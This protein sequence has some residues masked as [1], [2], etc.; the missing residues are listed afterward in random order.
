M[1]RVRL[2]EHNI[3][4][5]IVII[6]GGGAGLSAAAAAAEKGADVIV[7][8]KRNCTGGNTAMASNIFA[9][10][11]PVQKRAMVDASRDELFKAMIDW[12]HWR[13]D[14]RIIRAYV[15]KSGDTIR[16]LEDKGCSFELMPFFPN[17]TPLVVHKPAR[18]AM[19]TDML[20]KSC[21]ER[22]VKIFVRTEVQKILTGAGGEITGVLALRGNRTFNIDATRVI[23]CTGGYGGNKELINRYAP[24]YYDNM[25]CL[26]LP[27]TGDGL[28]LGIEAGA[29]TEGLGMLQIEGPCAP[30][31]IRLMID[32]PDSGQVSI[33]LTQIAIEPYA[34]WLNKN[35][36]RFIDETIGHSPF[37]AA[38]GVLR[39]PDGMCYAILDQSM[40]HMMAEEGIVIVRGPLAKLIGTSLPGLERELRIQSQAA[41]LS[42]SRV[43]TDLCNGCGVCVNSCPLN[44]ISLDTIVADR[45]ELSPCRSK[46]PARVDMRTYMYLL[47]QGMIEE[48]ARVITEKMPFP[49][50]TGRVCP[51]TC[52]SQCARQEVDEAVNINGVERFIGDWLLSRK[53]EPAPTTHTEKTAIIGSGPAGLACA[54]YLAKLGYP[55]IVFE[56]LPVL[57]GMLRFGIP[58]YRLPKRVLDAQ[59]Q[60]L[61]DMGVEFRTDTTIGEN[62][63]FTD[64]QAE[65]D[66]IF[67]ATGNQ[68]SRKIPLEGS[69]HDDVLWGVDFL[70]KVNLG[71]KMKVGRSVVIIG[72]GNVAIDVALTALRLGAKHVRMVCLESGDDIPAHPEEVEQA[73]AEGVIIDEGWGPQRILH[74]GSV[75]KGVELA[76]CVSLFDAE[77]RFAPCLDVTEAKN[78]NADMV[79]VA[80]G[81]APDLTL[82]PAAYE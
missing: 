34:V 19:V 25:R 29:A 30:R 32:A 57:G 41:A 5:D 65:Y 71:E 21:E 51:H 28:R 47:K 55:V 64:L 7:L 42:Y 18:K 54:Y 14:P 26:G 73:L 33:M 69:D 70:R 53:M 11:S 45:S 24:I 8:E 80:V 1:E 13:I 58:E 79:I 77:G 15:D 78:I 43:D 22:G 3:V 31:S 74:E 48:A 46:C 9:A 81:Q 68:L 72:G 61:K 60:Q 38:N 39:Q 67:F 36:R 66:A 59:I 12:A 37:V 16:W 17:Q 56:S 23:I 6:G 10:E 75:I 40:I 63:S 52:E 4:A 20:R 62:S 82:I 35:G 50:I 49:A 44:I 76:R 27:N 2:K